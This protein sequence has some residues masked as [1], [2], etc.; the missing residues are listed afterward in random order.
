MKPLHEMRH[1]LEINFSACTFSRK[2]EDRTSAI[3]LF[4]VD[5]VK[6]EGM[7]PPGVLEV[8]IRHSVFPF[9]NSASCSTLTYLPLTPFSSSFARSASSGDDRSIGMETTTLKI[10]KKTAT[11]KSQQIERTQCGGSLCQVHDLKDSEYTRLDRR[12]E[13][14]MQR[15][16]RLRR[17]DVFDF[18]NLV[19]DGH[20]SVGRRLPGM[21]LIAGGAYSFSFSGLF[22]PNLPHIWSNVA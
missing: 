3:V 13:L 19:D 11:T 2:K 14:V 17:R 10:R 5:S 15:P 22:V 16:D 9:S 21:S 6:K 4:I 7:R 8:A 12:R 20:V 18:G 1:I